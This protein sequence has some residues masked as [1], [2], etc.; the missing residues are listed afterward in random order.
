MIHETDG[1]KDWKPVIYDTSLREGMQT[2]GGIGGSLEERVYAANLISRFA[3]FVEI[4]MPANPVDYEIINAIKKSFIENKREA[5]IA[6]LCRIREDDIDKAEQALEGY[7]NTVAHLFIGTSDEHRRNRFAGKW[8]TSTYENNIEDMV[9]Y[10]ASKGFKH[11][12]F[13]PE[14][15]FRTFQESPED[16]FRF[17]DAAIKGY[18][19]GNEKIG[20]KEKLILN[21]PDTVGLSTLSEF[22][23]MLDSIQERYGDA[24]EVSLHGHDDNSTATPQAVD[25]FIKGK[26]RW[27]QTTFGNLGERNGIA[28][29][30]AVIAALDKRGYL[31][32]KHYG[33]EAVLN[34]LVPYAKGILG[35][36]GRTIPAEARVSGFRTNVSTA[37]IHTDLASKE[38]ITYHIHGDR[39]GAIPI[40]EFG[41]TSGS[42]QLLPLL[43][44]MGFKSKKHDDPLEEFSTYLKEKCNHEKRSLTETDVMYEAV[45]R[46]SDKED[47]LVVVNYRTS[48]DSE[49]GKTKLEMKCFYHRMERDLVYEDNGPVEATIGALNCLLN[50]GEDKALHLARFEP[51]VVPKIPWEYLNWEPG[52]YPDVPEDLNVGSSLRVV[53]GVR[54]TTATNGHEIYYGIASRENSEMTIVESVLDA[55]IKMT[56]IEQYDARR[57]EAAVAVTT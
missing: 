57:K 8:D 5:G 54:N 21:F 22:D 27:L 4:G 18:N 16:F 50:Q 12:M 51:S 17:V 32:G 48:T 41:P 20:R 45:K 31:K 55:A 39:Y 47:P 46:F 24:I 23:E 13:S 11:V 19:K 2:P 10:A 33:D 38:G 25:G 29:T 6:V 52:K 44:E 1:E 9:C 15:S 42:E 28:Q 30:E 37:G 7:D 43:T 34:L 36:L 26:S 49:T 40:L 56:A 3:D 53:T 35:A 14:D